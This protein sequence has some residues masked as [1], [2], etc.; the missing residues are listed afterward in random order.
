MIHSHDD[1]RVQS[2]GKA[3]QRQILNLLIFFGGEQRPTGGAD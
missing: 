1:C 3:K 2:I